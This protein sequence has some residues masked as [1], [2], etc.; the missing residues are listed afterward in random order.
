[1]LDNGRPRADLR[2][3]NYDP[4][5]RATLHSILAALHILQDIE[6]GNGGAQGVVQMKCN[7]KEAYK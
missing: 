1:M 2:P 4:Q 7:N 6:K 3:D 5:C